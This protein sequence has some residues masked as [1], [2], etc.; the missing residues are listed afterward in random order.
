M[1][2]ADQSLQLRR[3]EIV[4]TRL[5]APRERDDRRILIRRNPLEAERL[6]VEFISAGTAR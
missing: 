4:F 2:R 6:V 5:R 3:D 1:W